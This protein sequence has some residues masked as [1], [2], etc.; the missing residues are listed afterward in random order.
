MCGSRSRRGSAGARLS[1]FPAPSRAAPPP[2][3]PSPTRHVQSFSIPKG[4]A[5]PRGRTGG[6]AAG[7]QCPEAGRLQH[8]PPFRRRLPTA[9]PGRSPCGARGEQS[10]AARPPETVPLPQTQRRES[11]K[12]AARGGRSRHSDP[13]PRAHGRPLPP[14]G[15]GPGGA[16][17]P[18]AALNF[19]AQPG[20]GGGTAAPSWRA[21]ECPSGTGGR[22]G[23]RASPPLRSP[24]P[25][26]CPGAPPAAPSRG[27]SYLRLPWRRAAHKRTRGQAGGSAAG[28]QSPGAGRLEPRLR[29]GAW[30]APPAPPR[31]P[32]GPGSPGPR[33]L[34]CAGPSQ[35]AGHRVPSAPRASLPPAPWV[36]HSHFPLN[37]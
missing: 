3:G 13:A 4:P 1:E 30:S 8:R 2:G 6:A 5:G 26:L 37:R 35:R 21:H 25:H 24:P 31:R 19:G 20:G 34:A 23:G 29:A 12:V 11:P 27:P 22:G 15:P 10:R 28:G 7:G 17:G 36:H 9:L 18:A 14:R 33:V 32:L 16:P